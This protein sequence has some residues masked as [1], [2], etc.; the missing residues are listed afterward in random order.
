MARTDVPISFD[1]TPQPRPE[2]FK[3]YRRSTAGLEYRE[4]WPAD[5]SVIEHWGRCGERGETREHPAP[6]A[7]DQLKVL[8]RLKAAAASDG[9]KTIPI[10]RHAQLIVQRAVVGMGTPQD[11]EERHALESF[12]DEQTGWL[13]LGHCDGGSIGS[14]AMEAFCVVVDAEIASAALAPELAKSRF[15]AFEIAHIH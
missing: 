7:K 15:S 6:A 1:L 4:A 11:L 14:G 10:S 12:L 8:R 3:R 9:F 2:M 13:G 5:D